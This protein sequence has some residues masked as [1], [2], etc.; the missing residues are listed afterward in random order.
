MAYD[1]GKVA[2]SAEEHEVARA[3]DTVYESVR[4]VLADGA[5]LTDITIAAALFQP[6]MKIW[7]HLAGGSRED[8]ANRLIALGVM[9]ARDNEFIKSN[10]G[11]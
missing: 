1:E 3:A 10:P 11:E 2:F 4:T 6:M 5:Q 8:L 7:T 9:L